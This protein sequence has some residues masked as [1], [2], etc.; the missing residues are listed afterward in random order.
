MMEDHEDLFQTNSLERSTTYPLNIPEKH[1][2]MFRPMETPLTNTENKLILSAKSKNL[3]INSAN[4][5]PLTNKN[6]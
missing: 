4:I 5:N 2:N 6:P 1:K 3:D